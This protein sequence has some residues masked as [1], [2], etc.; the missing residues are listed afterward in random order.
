MLGTS[1]QTANISK[2]GFAKIGHT[3]VSKPQCV[4]FLT[5]KTGCDKFESLKNNFSQSLLGLFSP[6]PPRSNK[7]NTTVYRYYLQSCK[8]TT[9]EKIANHTKCKKLDVPSHL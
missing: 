6:E 4:K 8:A 7:T 1:E 9:F 3:A 2:T 5:K